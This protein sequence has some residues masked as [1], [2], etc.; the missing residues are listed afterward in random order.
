MKHKHDERGFHHIFLLLTVVVI[1]IVG[2]VGWRVFKNQS[3]SNSLGTSGILSSNDPAEEKAIKAG[4]YLSSG[5]CEGTDKVKLTHLP[6]KESDFS[7]V[8][9]YGL[10]VGGH[11]TPIDHQ[12][13]G[14]ADFKSP[15]DVYPVY[16]MGD[17]TITEITERTNERGTE[18]RFVF[19]YSCTSLYYYDLVTSLVGKV[20]EA[21]DKDRRNINLPVK[22]GEQV[23]KIGGQTLDFAVWDTEK[24]LTG[25]INPSS[26]DGEAWKI[27]TAD[28]YPYYSDELRALLAQRNP[29][30]TEPIAGKI[31]YDIDGKLIGNWFAQ[32]TGGYHAVDNRE[33]E[34]WQ[35]HLSFSPNHYDVAVFVISIGN[36]GGEAMQFV[37][38]GNTPNPAQV[39]TSTGLVKYQL[40]QFSYIKANGSFWDG[41][42]LTKNPKVRANVQDFGCL[43][44]QLVSARSLKAEPFPNKPCPSIPS[45][46]QSATTYER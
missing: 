22:A 21:Y 42:S 24:P 8:I 23:G 7:I 39:D 1:A 32:G 10:V 27:Y 20:K 29:R 13:F 33:Q 17:A 12:Y 40:R 11:V 26:Y 37:A 44:V 30:T 15:R 5:K 38:L 19:T 43:L 46:T 28:P 41:N 2:L 18:Y 31:D 16:A 6:M 36:F 14:P 9:P 3:N 35:E 34:Y 45:F 4:K 25:F